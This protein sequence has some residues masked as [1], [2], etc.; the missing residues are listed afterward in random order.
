MLFYHRTFEEYK[1][2]SQEVNLLK[3]RL[4]GLEEVI[5]ENTRLE[6]LLEF[7][8]RLIYSSIGANVIGRDP[9]RWNASII[10]DK[11][12][13]DGVAVGQPVVNESG[14]VGKI[15]EVSET[16][17]KIITV[18][19]PQ[20]SAAIMVQRSRESGV[21]SGTLKG[22]CRLKFINET[23]DIL[24][25]DQIITSKLSSAF[26]DSLMIGEVIEVDKGTRNSAKECLVKP[27]VSFSQLEEVL[28]ILK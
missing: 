14:V 21:V 19:D 3:A 23:A 15:A 18:I 16:K 13:R 11:G 20:F 10:I 4:I 9:S 2:K 6:K 24:V 1:K 7:K 8:R 5:K 17:S 27:I 28:I 22:I 26:P 12:S 25:G